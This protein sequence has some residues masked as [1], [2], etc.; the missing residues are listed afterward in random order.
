MNEAIERNGL[1]NNN[2]KFRKY[3]KK[4]RRFQNDCDM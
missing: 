1:Y 2:V 4:F 3:L